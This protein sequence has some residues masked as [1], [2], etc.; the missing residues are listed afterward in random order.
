MGLNICISRGVI[1][2][3]I[4]VGMEGK[5][6]RD[7][8]CIFDFWRKDEERVERKYP[9]SMYNEHYRFMDRISVESS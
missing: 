3:G 8:V 5:A 1:R 4:H 2:N 9:C 6:G 7:P